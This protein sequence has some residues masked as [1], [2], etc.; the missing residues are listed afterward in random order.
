VKIIQ[1]VL[2]DCGYQFTLDNQMNAEMVSALNKI[3]AADFL[4]S[5][6]NKRIDFYNHV[7]AHNPTQQK[8]LCHWLKRANVS[9]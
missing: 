3:D 9:G 2:N 6:K 4:L 7:V 8:F 1:R 5:I